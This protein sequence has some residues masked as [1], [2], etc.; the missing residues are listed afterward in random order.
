MVRH[1]KKKKK[2]YHTNSP[3]QSQTKILMGR[4]INNISIEKLKDKVLV[5]AI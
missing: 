4:K 1:Q 3:W 5:G 2:H